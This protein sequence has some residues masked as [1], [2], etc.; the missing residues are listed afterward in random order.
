MVCGIAY[1]THRFLAD[2]PDSDN[3]R[4]S[5]GYLQHANR[6]IGAPLHQQH[7]RQWP[8]TPVN[9]QPP[10]LM[11]SLTEWDYHWPAEFQV[12]EQ[13]HSW[14]PD[15]HKERWVKLQNSQ[16]YLSD[17]WGPHGCDNAESYLLACDNAVWS[18]FMNVSEEPAPSIIRV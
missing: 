4:N 5:R 14:Y 2:D 13:L 12:I 16:I 11:Y 17:E 9:F 1:D 15:G 18:K 7:Q 3:T 6:Y 10:P 8:V